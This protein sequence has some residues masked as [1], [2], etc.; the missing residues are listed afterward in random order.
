LCYYY[1][2]YQPCCSYH[3]FVSSN[4]LLPPFLSLRRK[5]YSVFPQRTRRG[6]SQ[7]RE[8]SLVFRNCPS[9]VDHRSLF[10]NLAQQYQKAPRGSSSQAIHYCASSRE[11]NHGF[12]P[13][14]LL[15]PRASTSTSR[16]SAALPLHMK[17]GQLRRPR[18]DSPRRRRPPRT[19]GCRS[20]HRR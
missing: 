6:C 7:V 16:T 15:Q 4:P 1:S 8:E 12:I 20:A 11:Q 3:P 2:Y 14:L 17:G 10:S 19:R 9:L 13:H 18:Q 5:K